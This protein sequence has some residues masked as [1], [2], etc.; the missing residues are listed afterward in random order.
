MV[1]ITIIFT[2][3][4]TLLWGILTVFIIPILKARTTAE[5]RARI[6][7]YID[8]AVS[9]AEILFPNVDG[10][11]MGKEKLEYVAL[12]L[13]NKGVTFDVDDIHDEI[14]VMIEGT[15]QDFF[16]N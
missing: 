15:V 3:V 5:Q 14:R 1:D 10:E 13:E 8:A 6:Q 7:T 16:G 2:A 4:I 9:A 11:K 12:C